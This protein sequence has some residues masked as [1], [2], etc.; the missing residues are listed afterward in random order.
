MK[1][2]KEGWF[3]KAVRVPQKWSKIRFRAGA[4]CESGVFLEDSA[5]FRLD[6]LVSLHFVGHQ[7]DGPRMMQAVQD[8]G[9]ASH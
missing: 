3:S 2:E 8:R 9:D 6:L 4:V 1:L 7:E 5:I